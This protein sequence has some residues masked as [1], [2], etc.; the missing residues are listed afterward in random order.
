MLAHTILHYGYLFIFAG[1]A[2]E[3]D[4]TLVTAAF[5]AHRGHFSLPI[6]MIIAVVGATLTDQ[7]IYLAVCRK[8]HA[9]LDRLA[10]REPRFARAELWVR[11]RGGLLLFLSRFILGF[12]TL[13]PAACAA[14]GMDGGRFFVINV[15]GAIAWSVIIGYAGYSGDHAVRRLVREIRL[16][17]VPVAA[18]LL[19]CVVC[20]LLVRT[21]AFRRR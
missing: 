1:V 19:L 18:V 5:L 7:V 21:G 14:A 6:V 17:E 3:G 13:I 4:A 2:L 16:H 11:D 10:A 15:A 12:R 20:Y 8:G 9:L